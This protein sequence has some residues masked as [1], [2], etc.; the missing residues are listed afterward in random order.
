MNT[1]V[2]LH[3]E[4]DYKNDVRII[5]QRL[6]RSVSCSRVALKSLTML[7]YHFFVLNVIEHRYSWNNC[8]MIYQA[9]AGKNDAAYRNTSQIVKQNMHPCGVYLSGFH[10]GIFFLGGGAKSI[11][12]LIFLLFSDQISGGARVSEGGRP[13]SPCGRKPVVLQSWYNVSSSRTLKS[14]RTT[15]LLT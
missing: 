14:F 4:K 12:M 9:N 2:P 1:Y 6:Y 7:W 5:V 11:V 15:K 3:F 8:F 10:P 13:L